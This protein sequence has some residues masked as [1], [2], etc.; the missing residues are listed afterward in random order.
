MRGDGGHI[1]L[2][3]IKIKNHTHISSGMGTAALGR[4]VARNIGFMQDEFPGCIPGCISENLIACLCETDD[5][6]DEQRVRKLL[7]TMRQPYE[8]NGIRCSV[9]I[10]G[11]ISPGQIGTSFDSLLRR[12]NGVLHYAEKTQSEGAVWYNPALLH[13]LGETLEDRG[14]AAQAIALGEFSVEFQPIVELATGWIAGVQALAVWQHPQ[15]GVVKQH[16]FVPILEKSGSI[17]DVGLFLISQS[18]EFFD[19]LKIHHPDGHKLS[20]CI[21]LSLVQ[22]FDPLFIERVAELQRQWSID[23]SKVVFVV[24]RNVR[25]LD[26]PQ[27]VRVLSKL[28]NL[29]FRLSVDYAI[30]SSGLSKLTS[31]RSESLIIRPA[32]QR[33]IE[34]PGLERTILRSVCRLAAEL[35]MYSIALGV[36]H[37]AA[38][39]PLIDC[40]CSHGIGPL[41][42]DALSEQEFLDIYAENA[43]LFADSQSRGAGI[44]MTSA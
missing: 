2:I 38:L 40:G 30:D 5:G 42:G 33:N 28:R 1:D 17:R 8:E 29:G 34:Q 37:H 26:D 16:K 3:L 7:N 9:D 13:D 41:F 20:V 44:D 14:D 11:S 25:A 22:L 19:R 36:A 10:C 23:G 32:L 4:I 15:H 24:T 27:I 43:A 35:D 21:N 12:G 39:A 18:F 31:V 6:L